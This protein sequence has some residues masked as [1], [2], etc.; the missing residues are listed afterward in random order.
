MS[1]SSSCFRP[2]SGSVSSGR[3]MLRSEE[4]LRKGQMKGGFRRL[5]GER[6]FVKIRKCGS[7]ACRTVD[8]TK[9]V[10][11]SATMPSACHVGDCLHPFLSP[12]LEALITCLQKFRQ[13]HTALL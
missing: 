1:A 7:M 2:V 6:S 9:D 10:C 8:G 11:L 12:F 5:L 3:A 13:C 4:W